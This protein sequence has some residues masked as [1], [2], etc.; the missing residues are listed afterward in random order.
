VD[1]ALQIFNGLFTYIIDHLL[2][3]KSDLIEI[4]RK[5]LNH[6]NLDIKLASLQAISNFL[7]SVEQKDTKPFIDL[8]PSMYSVIRTAAT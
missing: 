7:Q 3:F 8:I 2:K 4:F 1:A 5:T 6:A